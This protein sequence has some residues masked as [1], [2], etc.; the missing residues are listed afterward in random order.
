MDEHN[1][2][3]QI[4]HVALQHRRISEVIY[5]VWSA[6][7]P[8]SDLQSQH[9]QASSAGVQGGLL[10]TTTVIW[11]LVVSFCDIQQPFWSVGGTVGVYTCTRNTP[12]K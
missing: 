1:D 2:S 5:A 9:L 10:S 6:I 7:T 8:G 12:M 3:I 11:R 4:G